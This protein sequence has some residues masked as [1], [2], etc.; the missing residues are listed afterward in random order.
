MTTYC[1]NVL[2]IIKTWSLYSA[3]KFVT[4]KKYSVFIDSLVV[5]GKQRIHIQHHV[6]SCKY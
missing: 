1:S 4:G 2:K 5:G 3:D 6:R